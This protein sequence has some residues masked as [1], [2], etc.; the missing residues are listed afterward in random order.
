M[1]VIS[2]IRSGLEFAPTEMAEALIFVE[3]IQRATN[4]A[5]VQQ[6][7]NKMRLDGVHRRR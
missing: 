5:D 7:V 3:A 4:S 6:V 1:I 2:S